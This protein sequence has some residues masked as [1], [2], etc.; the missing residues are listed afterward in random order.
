MYKCIRCWVKNKL[1][2]VIVLD[3]WLPEVNSTLSL[4]LFTWQKPLSHCYTP[5]QST[6]IVM[7]I[8]CLRVFHYH[9]LFTCLNSNNHHCSG[10]WITWG[11]FIIVFFHMTK[12]I[13]LLIYTNTINYHC[14]ENWL[15]E[16]ISLLS[17]VH[18]P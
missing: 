8:D 3:N 16:G 12:T 4:F 1:S 9:L 15:P 6:I 7:K 17:F 10:Q 18:M 5:I 2:I 11:K 13:E 14:N